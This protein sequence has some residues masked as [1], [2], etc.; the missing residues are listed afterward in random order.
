MFKWGDGPGVKCLFRSD[1]DIGSTDL[2]YDLLINSDGDDVEV[3][4]ISVLG[5][6]SSCLRHLFERTGIHLIR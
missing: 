3:L 2:M 6:L 5:V 1:A 4:I